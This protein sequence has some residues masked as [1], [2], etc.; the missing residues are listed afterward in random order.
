MAV[1]PGWPSSTSWDAIPWSSSLLVLYGLHPETLE[2]RVAG[3]VEQLEPKLRRDGATIELLGIED[4][5]VR[6]RVTPG[7][8]TCGSTTKAL[9]QQWRKRFT[10]PRRYRF[11]DRSK[12]SMG[13][14][15]AVLSP[16]GNLSAACRQT[17]IRPQLRTRW[18]TMAT[19]ESPS[20]E[21][22]SVCCGSLRASL[23]LPSA[24]NCA[25]RRFP[26]GTLTFWIRRP[27]S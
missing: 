10:K 8:H 11:A 22:L 17:L 26:R 2:T 21:R 9:Q 13:N 12:A 18:P 19:N 16:L 24:A 4:G 5:A 6:I 3:A 27:A 7:A 25:A 20:L 1:T 15:P 14:R 23:A